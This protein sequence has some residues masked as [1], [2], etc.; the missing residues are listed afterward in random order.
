MQ[1]LIVEGDVTKDEDVQRIIDTTVSKF[2]SIDVLVNNAGDYKVGGLETLTSEQFNQ[3][4]DL[5]VTS[6]F[7]TAKAARSHLVKSKGLY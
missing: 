7:R 3:E 2:H 6:M 5:N 1:I 4:Y